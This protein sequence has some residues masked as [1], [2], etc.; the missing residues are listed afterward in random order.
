MADVEKSPSSHV[1]PVLSCIFEDGSIRD[2]SFFGD[3]SF[4]NALAAWDDMAYSFEQDDAMSESKL[5][6]RGGQRILKTVSLLHS[7]GMYMLLEDGTLEV[8]TW[9]FLCLSILYMH[10]DI[11]FAAAT[12]ISHKSRYICV[13]T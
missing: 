4:K 10:I 3:S 2:L 1:Y 11:G 6:P 12:A 8:I 5:N 7:D 9:P 13:N